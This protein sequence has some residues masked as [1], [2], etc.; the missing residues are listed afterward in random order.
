MER[1]AP[2][3]DFPG[4]EVSDHGRVRN[5][6]GR[7]L[8]IYDNGGGTLQV[9]LRR[10]GRNNARAVNRLVAI[11][12]ISFEDYDHTPMH[13]DGDATNNHADNLVW[14]PRWF[15]NRQTRQRNRTV[16]MDTRGIIIEG[17]GIRADQHY[18]NALEC[19]REIGGLEE[20][21]L[22]AAQSRNTSY[23]GMNFRFSR[24]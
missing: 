12:H 19:A 14:K 10:D 24:P 16:A 11:A 23:M 2:I 7:I 1:W 18:E 3:E 21:V 20:M 5:S 22:I 9:T 13:I 6:S 15:A 4:Y 8:G 17:D